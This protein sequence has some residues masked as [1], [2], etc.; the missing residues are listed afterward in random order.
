MGIVPNAPGPGLK[1]RT[2]QNSL[3]KL[4][5]GFAILIAICLIGT[6]ALFTYFY[7]SSPTAR[8]VTGSLLSRDYSPEKAF[9]NHKEVNI[10]LMGKDLDRDRHG[11]IIHTRGRTDTMMVAHFDFQNRSASI[12][13]IPRDTLVH[14]PGYRGRHRVSY[15]NAYGG[16]ELAKNTIQEFL[17]VRPDYHVLLN[18]D[19]FENA[20][21]C[22]GGLEATVDKKLDYDDNWGN[23]HIHLTP[24]RQTLNGKQA[25]GFVRYRQSNDGDAESDFLRIGRQQELL[26]SARE[27][28]SSPSVMFKVPKALDIIRND[29]DSDLTPAQMICLAR[30]LKTLPSDSTIRMETIPAA[31]GSG[32]FVH[33]DKGETM[34]LVNQMFFDN[35]Q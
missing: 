24:G 20:I 14:I 34:K 3:R 6:T 12:L 15:A 2:R 22:V 32:V 31:E 35:Q 25:M 21:D 11:R 26:R 13:S 4:I 28:L 9:P 30:C 18:F 10:L 16:P 8:D 27:K 19:A 1:P 23:L 33:P 29:A 17:G 7:S 5:L